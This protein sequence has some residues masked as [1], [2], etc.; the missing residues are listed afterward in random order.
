MKHDLGGTLDR[1]QSSIDAISARGA[2]KEDENEQITEKEMDDTAE[3]DLQDVSNPVARPAA[4]NFAEYEGD[5]RYDGCKKQESVFFLKTSKTGSTTIAN[6]LT[7][8]GY[9]QSKTFLL[10]EQ[11]NGGIWFINSYLPFSENVCFLGRDIPNRPRIDISACH[12]RYNKTAIDT[13]LQ[14]YNRKISILRSVFSFGSWWLK[15]PNPFQE[16][17]GQLHQLVEILSRVNH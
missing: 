6:I 13:V 10:G 15:Y 7:R 3:L 17:A 8:F 1:V 14:P 9:A 11:A 12:I 4:M 2:L 5:F 16:P